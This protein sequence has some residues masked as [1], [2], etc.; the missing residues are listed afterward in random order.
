MFERKKAIANE[1]INKKKKRR[2]A[3]NFGV[4]PDARGRFF[5]SG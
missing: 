4:L 1:L 2:A 3:K 5:F